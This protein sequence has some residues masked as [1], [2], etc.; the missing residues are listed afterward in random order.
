MKI[1]EELTE[2]EERVWWGGEG[3]ERVRERL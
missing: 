3:V 1:R 2:D